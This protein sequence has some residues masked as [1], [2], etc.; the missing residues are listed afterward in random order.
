MSRQPKKWDRTASAWSQFEPPY[1]PVAEESAV[2]ERVA[3]EL[4]GEGGRLNAV[5]LGVTPQ[6]AALAWPAGVCLTAFD[7]SAAMIAE[8]WPAPGT[9]AGA[10]AILADWSELPLGVGSV[11]LIAGDHSLGVLAW[12]QGPA[13]LLAELRRVLKPGGRFVLRSFLRPEQRE[14]LDAIVGDLE[15]GRIRSAG[16]AKMRFIAWRHDRGT[17]GISVQELKDLFKRY[18]PD[19]DEAVRRYGWQRGPS[20]IPTTEGN[21]RRFVFPTLAEL[22][23][24]IAPFFREIECVTGSHELAERFPTMVLEPR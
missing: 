17:E 11:D 19:P 2:I 23:D 12:P 4:A 21:E 16:I 9:P 20:D 8:L 3:A 15:A 14:D 22:R 7:N 10:Q 13:K 18:V 5:I 1:L 24:A 6:T